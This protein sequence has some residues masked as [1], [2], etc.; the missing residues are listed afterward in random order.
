MDYLKLPDVPAS[1]FFIPLCPQIRAI[2]GKRT[3]RARNP[4]ESGRCKKQSTLYIQLQEGK[5]CHPAGVHFTADTHYSKKN[6]D[7]KCCCTIG[8]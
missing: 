7:F 3:N 4:T 5:I 6:V 2:L 1:G 8:H